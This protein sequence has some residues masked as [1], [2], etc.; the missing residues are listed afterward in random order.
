MCAKVIAC[1]IAVIANLAFEPKNGRRMIDM[2]VPKFL[3]K[4]LDLCRSGAVVTHICICIRNM[5][6]RRSTPDWQEWVGSKDEKHQSIFGEVRVLVPKL[7]CAW[8]RMLEACRKD[9]LVPMDGVMLHRCSVA[10]LEGL[11]NCRSM[12]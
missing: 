1:C 11:V 4:M 5:A 3:V 10:P 12:L 2:G 8:C 6:M 9:P 7:S